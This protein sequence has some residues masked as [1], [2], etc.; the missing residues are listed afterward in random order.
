MMSKAMKGVL[1]AVASALALSCM[2]ILGKLLLQRGIHPLNV[3]TLRAIVAFVTLAVILTAARRRLPTIALGQV[4]FF[5]MLG[6]IGISLNYATFFL[7]LDHSSVSTAISL[8]YTYPA[9][10]TVGAVLFLGEAMTVKK[11]TALVLTIVGCVFVT[12]AYD[13]ASLELNALGVL[14]GLSASLTKS[15]YTLLSKRALRQND[16]W[17][18]VLF[19][20]GFGALFLTCWTWP[21]SILDID[22]GWEAWALILAIAWIPTLI[23]YSLFVLSLSYLEA[24]RASMIATLEPA[25]AILLAGLFLGEL[26]AW[27]QFFGVGLILAG[28]IVLNIRTAAAP[29]RL[30]APKARPR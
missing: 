13:P 4:P 7:A 14:F 28:I 10:V 17:T 16:P 8:L 3:V 5:A 23:G 18:T 20:F 1:A 26:G 15:A 27:P 12:G 29:V 24:S 2:G 11:I 25:A 9:F 30:P 21:A 6:L 19:A 22:I